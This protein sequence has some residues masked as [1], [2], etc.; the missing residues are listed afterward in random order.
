MTDPNIQ[1]QVQL[2]DEIVK[3]ISQHI[4]N[5]EYATETRRLEYMNEII[6]NLVCNFV[7]AYT[8]KDYPEAFPINILMAIEAISKTSIIISQNQFHIDH[9]HEDQLND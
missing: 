9:K 3:K 5:K 2:I 7:Y 1:E 4:H 8:N 6:G